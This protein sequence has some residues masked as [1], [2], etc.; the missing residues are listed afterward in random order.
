MLVFFLCSAVSSSENEDM[1]RQMTDVIDNARDL[2]E[3]TR[4]FF[5]SLGNSPYFQI[6]EELR[7]KLIAWRADYL[8]ENSDAYKRHNERVRQARAKWYNEHMKDTE[9]PE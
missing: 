1:I 8:E 9:I 5:R 3:R 6:I 4:A 2:A 7:Q